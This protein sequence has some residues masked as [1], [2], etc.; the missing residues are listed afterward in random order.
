MAGGQEWGTLMTAKK[1]DRVFENNIEKVAGGCWNWVGARKNKKG[2]G[3]YFTKTAHRVSYETYVGVIPKGMHVLHTC[4]N[5]KCVNPSHLH[6]GTN[7][8]NIADKM[9]KGRYRTPRSITDRIPCELCG[10]LT[11]K[12]TYKKH[13]DFCK[14]SFPHVCR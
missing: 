11:Q 14:R 13:L 6:I 7:N 12:A 10:R 4:D 3:A 2:Y 5:T 1:T 8:D 9:A